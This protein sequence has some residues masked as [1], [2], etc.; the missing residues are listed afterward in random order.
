MISN[1]CEIF[2]D[3]IKMFLFNVQKSIITHNDHIWIE[4]SYLLK[5]YA[6]K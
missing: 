1:N 6:L 4:I 5:N 2:Y 3:L